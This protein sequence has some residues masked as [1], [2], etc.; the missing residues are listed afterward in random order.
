MRD[1]FQIRYSEK[2]LDL[3]KLD[4]HLR[5]SLDIRARGGSKTW[6]TME[7]A[8]YLASIGFE[9]IWFAAVAKQ[10]EQP[11]KY[12]KYIVGKSYLKYLVKT[13]DLLKE[14]VFF[15]TGGELKI[16]NLTEDNARSPRCDFVIYDEEARADR[17]AYDAGTSIL[18]NSLLGLSFHISTACKATIFEEN[19]DRIKIR[20]ITTG[21]QF[22]FTRSW[23]EIS[24]LERKRAWYEEEKK[25]KPAW[26]FR[27]EHECS[28]ELPMGAVFQNVQFTEYPEWLLEAVKDQ[29]LLSGLDWNPVAGH[30]LVSK[31]WTKDLMNSV[32]MGEIDLG[33]GYA[34][35][36]TNDQWDIIKKHAS[37]GNHLNYECSGLNEEYVKWLQKK[38]SETRFNWPDQNWHSEEWDSQGVNKLRIATFIIQNGIC[39][40]CDRLRFPNTAKQIEDCQWD[41]DSPIP[42]LKKDPASSPHYLDA[43]LHAASEENR[44]DTTFTFEE[45][46]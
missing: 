45:W 8:L 38:K 7:I 42:K 1:D 25:I 20:E 19:Y 29:P 3:I 28:F 41:P 2:K 44:R 33:Q 36:M 4:F 9:G 13:G 31:K 35:Q 32:V 6:D 23:Y 10:M 16:Y 37:H 30:M 34:V 18:S 40:W 17:D 27:Q 46:Y 12:L 43:Y 26:Y 21:E 24:F 15:T 22:I 11:K 39:I 5:E 14:S